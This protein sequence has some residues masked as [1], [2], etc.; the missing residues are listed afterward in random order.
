QQLIVGYAAPEKKRQPGS[1]LQI[2]KAIDGPR[3]DVHRDALDAEEKLRVR[4]N[5][6]NGELDRLVEP[7]RLV[8]L[9]KTEERLDVLFGDGPTIGPAGK[10][11]ENRPG[12]ALLV[13]CAR[14]PADEDPATARRIAGAGDLIRAADHDLIQ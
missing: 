9:E 10:S 7:D 12:A 6:F 5:S 3:F 11:G 13:V 14:G 4:Q 1:K 2:G 8:G